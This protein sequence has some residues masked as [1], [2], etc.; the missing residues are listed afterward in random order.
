MIF[1]IKEGYDT[2]TVRSLFTLFFI[3]YLLSVYFVQM[4]CFLKVDERWTFP[5]SLMFTLSVITMIG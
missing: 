5:S 2:R 4:I 3:Y 1:L